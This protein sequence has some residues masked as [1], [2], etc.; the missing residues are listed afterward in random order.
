MTDP[1]TAL[2]ERSPA[3]EDA[4]IETWREAEPDETLAGAVAAALA[5]GRPQLAA[6]LVG[7]LDGRVEIPPGSPLQRARRA[8]GL[9]LLRREEPDP[10]DIEALEEAWR[11][12]Q[13]GRLLRA[14]QRA[15]QRQPPGLLDLLT[16]ADPR[17]KP[18]LTG[19][20]RRG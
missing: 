18:R 8:A 17:R 7:L 16:P 12:V 2:P 20:F 6:R 3:A 19:R 5:A 9:L 14:R 1:K 10:Q 15:R 13:Q 4:W 11:A